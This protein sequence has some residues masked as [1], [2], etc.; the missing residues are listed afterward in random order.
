[1]GAMVNHRDERPF[2][3][4]TRAAA[5]RLSES[6][7]QNIVNLNTAGAFAMAN[8]RDEFFVAFFCSRGERC[9]KAA[10]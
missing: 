2:E 3:A 4:P 9:G 7:L 6:I 10:E 8:H 1:M 5:Q